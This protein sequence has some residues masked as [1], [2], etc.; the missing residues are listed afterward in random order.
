MG[1][2]MGSPC[3]G[4]FDV[5]YDNAMNIEVRNR[6]IQQIN[7]AKQPQSI[8][9]RGGNGQY[10]SDMDNDDNKLDESQYAPN[11]EIEKLLKIKGNDRCIDCRATFPKWA[12]V[13]NGC[14]LCINC[15]AK[16][17]NMG[18]NISFVRSISLDSWSKIQ[19]KRMEYGGNATLK[20]Y[21]KDQKFPKDLTPEQRLNN[22]AMDKYRDNLLR[23]AKEESVEEIP[24]IGY[25]KREIIKRKLNK[26]NMV[27]FGNS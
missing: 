12:S 2:E 17:R 24:F 23:K 13:N 7:K 14:F 25:Q 1:A 15:A 16:H 5:K 11:K 18:V 27:G 3:C 22:E 6:E 8:V 26:K 9:P 20:K 10:V 19:L 4:G 21:W